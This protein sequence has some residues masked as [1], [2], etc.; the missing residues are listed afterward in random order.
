MIANIP[1]VKRLFE[2]F[3]EDEVGA[4]VEVT[5]FSG[6]LTVSVLEK[7]IKLML[8]VLCDAITCSG[9]PPMK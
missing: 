6:V 2:K 4:E 3:S 9:D 1:F 7:T 5:S 8:D